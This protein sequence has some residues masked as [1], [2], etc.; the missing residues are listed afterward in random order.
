VGRL[1]SAEFLEVGE[2]AMFIRDSFFYMFARGFPAVVTLATLATFTR[3]LDVE[4][5]AIYSIVLVV[6]I[7]VK[8]ILFTWIYQATNRFIPGTE[9]GR[10]MWWRLS[11]RG[12]LLSII[13]LL[14]F[15][16]IFA[17]YA[18]LEKSVLRIFLPIV[19]LIGSHELLLAYFRSV[20]NIRSYAI[21][22]G[23]HT[24]SALLIGAL[25]ILHGYGLMGAL[26]GYL[27]SLAVSTATGVLLRNFT[28]VEGS[29]ARGELVVS[30][31]QA[32]LF[33][34]PAGLSLVAAS[35]FPVVDR[36]LLL[37]FST[38]E[39]AGSYAAGYEFSFKTIFVVINI[40]NLAAFPILVSHFRFNAARDVAE[41]FRRSLSLVIYVAIPALVA[42]Y[43]LRYSL[44]EIFVGEAYRAAFVDILPFLGIAALASGLALAHLS[45]PMLLF[46]KVRPI[47]FIVF[48]ALGLNAG[49]NVILIPEFGYMGAAWSSA[50]SAIIMATLM[51]RLGR[52][53]FGYRLPWLFAIRVLA[54]VAV[55]V[56]A[57]KLMPVAQPVIHVCSAVIIGGV[58]YAAVARVLGVRLAEMDIRTENAKLGGARIV[59]PEVVNARGQWR[60]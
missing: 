59:L 12:F 20:R 44:A 51:E 14:I 42:I 22:H 3:L 41:I 34:F 2:F 58:T 36:L 29:D 10:E 19:I 26:L 37:W 13:P 23:V 40:L 48:I 55:M 32:F 4:D 54:A 8:G 57:I 27:I 43:V 60:E 6:V 15:W 35:M 28:K 52:R 21:I 24:L 7:F 9:Q 47:L 33:G 46:Q 45:Y 17:N 56:V 49:A 25:L 16:V 31:K 50:L 1:E 5:Y 11:W 53:C 30:L 39:A 18:L 38:A